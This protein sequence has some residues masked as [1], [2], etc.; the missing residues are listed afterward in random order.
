M[1]TIYFVR[2]AQSDHTDQDERGRGLSAQ[3]Q[4]DVA[5]VTRFL[6]GEQVDAAFSSPYQRAI[7]T[8]ADYTKRHNMLI[9]PL[10]GFCEWQ[11]HEDINVSF[12]ELCRRHWADFD[13]RY[14]GGESLREVQQRNVAALRRVLALCKDKNVIIGTHGMA[15]STII[16]FYEPSFGFADFSHL[17]P[18]VPLIVKMTFDGERCL[19]IQQIDPMAK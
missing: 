15:L 9:Q 11:R 19:H 1:T 13:Y 12:E 8:I 3:G 5:W 10:E 2:H 16:C 6:E 14:L 4:R 18:L 17:L 7:D